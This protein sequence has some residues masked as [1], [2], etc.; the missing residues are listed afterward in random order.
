MKAN[1]ILLLI[2]TTIYASIDGDNAILQKDNHHRGIVF[3]QNYSQENSPPEVKILMPED[4]KVYTWNTQVRYVINV[5][6]ATDGDSKY[7][8]IDGNKVL[9]EIEY[10]P[11]GKEGATAEQIKKA[12]ATPEPKGLA[13]LKQSTCLG[14]HADKTRVAG[15]SFQEIAG[16]Y[17]QNAAVI[18]SL[19][20]H[21]VKGSSGIW[22][23]ME[24]PAHPDLT[25]DEATQIADYILK[26][27]ANKYRWIYPGLEGAFRIINKPEKNPEGI[28]I[29]T[30]RY[31]TKSNVPGMQSII[32]K[33]K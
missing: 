21:I 10:L 3:S 29:L 24:M 13:L 6:D 12:Q 4:N 32:L 27:G 15:P 9:L 18:S 23:S 2:S 7:G 31:T 8:E 25:E 16:K 22:G 1:S 26:Q 28:Y 33:I 19:A 14:C 20:A 30:A 17:E 11:A 5:S